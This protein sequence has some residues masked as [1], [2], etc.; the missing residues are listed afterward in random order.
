MKKHPSL[1]ILVAVLAPYF[2]AACLD[3]RETDPCQSLALAVCEKTCG[4]TSEKTCTASYRSRCLTAKWSTTQIDRCVDA[5]K[6]STDCATLAD[7]PVACGSTIPELGS[8]G[9]ECSL[10]QC[11]AGLICGAR[12]CGKHCER[13]EDCGG[14]LSRQGRAAYCSAVG[15]CRQACESDDECGLLKCVA[16]RDGIKICD[17]I[18]GPQPFKSLGDICAGYDCDPLSTDGC[19]LG[20]CSKACDTNEDCAALNGQNLPSACVLLDGQGACQPTCASDVD[21]APRS[22]SEVAT[23]DGTTARTCVVERGSARLGDACVRD[24]DCGDARALCSGICVVPC[25]SDADCSYET[26]TGE[27]ARCARLASSG[28]MCVAGCN[29]PGIKCSPTAACQ[30]IGEGNEVC[31]P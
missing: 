22:C 10:V 29:G 8:I 15:D 16:R 7:F 2:A 9:D 21:C 4:S 17:P 19:V 28:Q 1:A 31:V 12:G 11:Q 14:L 23:L 20:Y 13:D 26:S 5:L 3:L 6:S 27:A 24:D 30:P 25:E 18:H